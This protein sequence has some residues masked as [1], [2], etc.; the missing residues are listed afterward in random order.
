ME[1]AQELTERS[2]QLDENG[3]K[4]EFDN[5]LYYHGEEVPVPPMTQEQLERLIMHLESV[6]TT[7]FVNDSIMNIISEEMGSFFAGDKTAEEVAK[8]IQNRAELYVQE[9]Q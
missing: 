8:L 2:F 1:Q 9:N 7:A 4:V 6:K 5:T 3:V